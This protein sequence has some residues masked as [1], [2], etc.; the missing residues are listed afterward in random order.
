LIVGLGLV[1]SYNDKQ[2][3]TPKNYLRR[4]SME[5]ELL[6]AKL[7][8][9]LRLSL[10]LDWSLWLTIAIVSSEP[11]HEL[12]NSR[13]ENVKLRRNQSSADSELPF[14]LLVLYDYMLL[15]S[16]RGIRE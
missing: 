9:M 10:L 5:V 7:I 1:L 3:L 11:A 8:M 6:I 16:L 14:A 15:L 12:T 4:G 2:S 13:S